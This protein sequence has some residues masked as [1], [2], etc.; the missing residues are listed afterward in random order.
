MDGTVLFVVGWEDGTVLVGRISENRMTVLLAPSPW[1]PPVSETAFYLLPLAGPLHALAPPPARARVRPQLNPAPP[2]LRTRD[3]HAPPP[4]RAS[5]YR[6]PSRG[7]ACQP[8]AARHRRPPVRTA[9]AGWPRELAPPPLALLQKETA[10][11]GEK[12]GASAFAGDALIIGCLQPP[13]PRHRSACP[14]SQTP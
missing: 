3:Q 8:A 4:T 1:V 11:D 13:N 12:T 10:R 5:S 14:R 6:L 9:T 7:C 2:P